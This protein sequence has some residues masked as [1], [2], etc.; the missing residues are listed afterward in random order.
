MCVCVDDGTDYD[1][2]AICEARVDE[3]TS[4]IIYLLMLAR[5]DDATGRFRIAVYWSARDQHPLARLILSSAPWIDRLFAFCYRS[6][7]PH[8]DPG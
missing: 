8:Y 6:Q 7:A 3:V 1:G 5:S 4:L 2:F